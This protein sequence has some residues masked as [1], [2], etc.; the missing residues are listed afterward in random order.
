MRVTTLLLV[1]LASSVCWISRGEA[2]GAPGRQGWGGREG[3]LNAM[4][5]SEE[6]RAQLST[7]RAELQQK[8]SAI[9]AQVQAGTLTPE[10]AREQIRPLREAMQAA[11][12][13]ILT[14]EQKAQLPQRGPGRGSPGFQPQQG[15]KPGEGF[16]QALGLTDDQQAKLQAL[17]KTHRDQ[18]Q[19]AR[20]QEDGLSP[21]ERRAL[22][23]Q[24]QEA[25]RAELAKLL[26]PDQL[27]KL[28]ALRAAR[29]ARHQD[30]PGSEGTVSST[31]AVKIRTSP[32]AVMPQSWGQV[33]ASQV[34]EDAK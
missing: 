30:R 31:S 32:T 2:G 11:M 13:N 8:V 23:Q 25:M 22:R 6:Q 10:A 28:E 19:E 5:L 24:Q 9:R 7:A 34:R 26:T 12:G 29:A 33:K 15:K 16:G 17:F 21:E 27:T 3:R 20:A 18:M 4:N 1:V 14:E